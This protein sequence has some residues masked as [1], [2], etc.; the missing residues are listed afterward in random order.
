MDNRIRARP[1]NCPVKKVKCNWNMASEMSGA[2]SQKIFLN[3]MKLRMVELLIESL[4]E[5][6]LLVEDLTK[7]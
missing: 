3:H 5:C 7:S 4:H 6:A 1:K 2:L